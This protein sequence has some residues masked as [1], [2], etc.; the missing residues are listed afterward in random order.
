M[1]LKVEHYPSGITRV[2]VRVG[3]FETRT[4]QQRALRIL[5]RIGREL[6]T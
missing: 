4:N 5:E 3:T 1:L 2:R 6:G